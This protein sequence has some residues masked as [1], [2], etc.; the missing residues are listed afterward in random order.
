V[1]LS[2]GLQAKTKQATSFLCS[3]RY[4]SGTHFRTSHV[5]HRRCGSR[6]VDRSSPGPQT[7]RTP[8][9]LELLQENLQ[10]CPLVRGCTEDKTLSSNKHTNLDASKDWMTGGECGSVC[11]SFCWFLMEAHDVFE[12]SLG[13]D[14]GCTSGYQREGTVSLPNIPLL[15]YPEP[16]SLDSR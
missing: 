6:G 16:R 2:I 10:L 14:S 1:R 5:I 9:P 11:A 8:Y 15:Q 4:V 3:P 13:A 7:N 12:F